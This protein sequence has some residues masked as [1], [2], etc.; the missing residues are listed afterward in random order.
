[1]TAFTS[2]EEDMKSSPDFEQ[3]VFHRH[4]LEATV[5]NKAASCRH[6]N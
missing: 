2:C 5:F 4:I 6:W 1:M 3:M